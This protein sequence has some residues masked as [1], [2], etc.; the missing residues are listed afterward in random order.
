MIES[1]IYSRRRQA[2]DCAQMSCS[3]GTFEWLVIP[4]RF[5]NAG[6]AYQKVINFILR[7]MIEKFMEVHIDEIIV[8]SD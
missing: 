4:F 3:I 1:N 7:D 6:T 5:K 2:H 8:L